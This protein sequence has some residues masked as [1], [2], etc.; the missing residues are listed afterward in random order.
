MMRVALRTCELG[1]VW[2]R[3]DMSGAFVIYVVLC[4][5]CMLG[6]RARSSA[7]NWRSTERCLAFTL[8]HRLPVP[9]C[10]L[11]TLASSVPPPLT[12]WNV[13]VID[14]GPHRH[15]GQNCVDTL[16]QKPER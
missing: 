9:G 2:D 15:Q 11:A 4:G 14:V 8:Q 3:W 1:M 10:S 5:M 16:D 6:A 13:G 12:H 7:Q